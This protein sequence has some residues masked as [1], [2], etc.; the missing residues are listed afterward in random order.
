M[1]RRKLLWKVYPYYFAIIIVSLVLTAF[2]ASHE[3]K[4]MHVDEITHALEARARLIGRQLAKP[5]LESDTVVLQYH[6]R[7]LGALSATRITVVDLNGVVLADSE[8][9]AESMENHGNRPEIAKAYTGQVGVQ[10]R[11][12]NTLQQTMTYVAVPVEID[13]E[14]VGIVRTSYPLTTVE[15][16]LGTLYGKFAVG[17]IVMAILATV[18][19]LFVFRRLTRPLQELRE[20][21]E[22]FAEG[23][24]ES[25]LRIPETEEIAALAESM[26]RMAADLDARIHTIVEQRNE[27]E[28]ILSSMSEGILALDADEK[29]VS[30]NKAAARFLGIDLGKAVGRPIQEAARIASLHDFVDRTLRSSAPAEM[31]ITFQDETQ[32]CLQAHG[33]VLTDASGKRIGVVLVFN[34]ITR[35]KRLETI[36]RDFVANVSHELKTPITAITGSVE[37]LLDGAMN[38]Q[39]DNERFLQMIAKHSERLDNLVEDLLSLARLESES[40]RGAMKLTR[41]RIADILESSVQA[42]HEISI[43]RKVAVSSHCAPDLEVDVNPT[44]IEQAIT[45]LI[46]NAIKYSDAGSE[47][48]V[49][50]DSSENEIIISVQD[51]GCGIDGKHLPRLFER[52]YQVDKARSREAGGTGLGLAIVKHVALAH[53]GRVSVSS[54]PGFGSTFRIHIPGLG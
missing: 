11:Y 14:M 5:L 50:A 39:E 30:L 13:G 19:S 25:K 1:K 45:N 40:E 52:F 42:C 51:Q 18:V 12:S 33:A 28:A 20:G 36:R 44:Q 3:M 43:L 21:A 34:D 23:R 17:G 41:C 2:Y 49:T 16:A 32:R 9:D 38:S 6:C 10:T 35:L 31:E 54:K 24:L 7:D 46:D 22:R 47:V 15:Q 4:Q 26:N 48:N 29:I 8:E 53:R 37:T 27:R